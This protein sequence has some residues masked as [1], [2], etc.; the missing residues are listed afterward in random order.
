MY[1]C[2]FDWTKIDSSVQLKDNLYRL[3]ST[4]TETNSL[5]RNG[6]VHVDHMLFYQV[7]H[8][9]SATLALNCNAGRPACLPD[10]LVVTCMTIFPV[11]GVAVTVLAGGLAAPIGGA[12]IGAGCALVTKP[13]AKQMTGECMN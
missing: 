3:A 8:H 4:Q 2:I 9:I 12:I 5:R 6:L 10:L 13:I 11:D 7:C 1:F